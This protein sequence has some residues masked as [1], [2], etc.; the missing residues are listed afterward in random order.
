M[1]TVTAAGTGTGL[2]GLV[3]AV[4]GASGYAL[5]GFGLLLLAAMATTCWVIADRARTRHAVALIAATR[6]ESAAHAPR[7]RGQQ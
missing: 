4:A 5:A 1:K 3:T 7:T 6:G 2:A